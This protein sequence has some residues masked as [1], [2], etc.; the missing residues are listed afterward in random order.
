VRRLG[1][2]EMQ[3][4]T[5]TSSAAPGNP[6]AQSK[7]IPRPRVAGTASGARQ[8]QRQRQ[9]QRWRVRVRAARLRGRRRRR[10]NCGQARQ[11]TLAASQSQCGR[12]GRHRRVCARGGRAADAL[13]SQRGQA[14]RARLD[15]ATAAAARGSRGAGARGARRSAE[16]GGGGEDEGEQV[17]ARA[18]AHS[19]LASEQH[20][21]HDRSTAGRGAAQRQVAGGRRGPGRAVL[22]CGGESVRGSGYGTTRCT[23]AVWHVARSTHSP[24]KLDRSANDFQKVGSFRSAQSSADST[25]QR[26][27]PRLA[28]SLDARGRLAAAALAPRARCC[29]LPPTFDS[30]LEVPGLRAQAVRRASA[31]AARDPA[32]R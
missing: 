9:R 13:G 17:S 18:A 14:A 25:A 12:D 28:G 4:E 5:T 16:G 27:P 3:S 7:A 2:T 26:S 31:R 6:V 30:L 19:W 10:R 20:R 11:A 22:R 1:R 15:A 23:K 8:R 24:S 29:T 32:H 21:A